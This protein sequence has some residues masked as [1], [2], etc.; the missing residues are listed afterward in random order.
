M[1]TF[2]LPLEVS[3]LSSFCVFFLILKTREFISRLT[4]FKNNA[5]FVLHKQMDHFHNFFFFCCFVATDPKNA[6]NCKQMYALY[7]RQKTESFSKLQWFYRT[8]FAECSVG[9]HI[10]TRCIVYWH[11]FLL[12]YCLPYNSS[13]EGIS[14]VRSVNAMFALKSTAPQYDYYDLVAQFN[15]PMHRCFL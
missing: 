14:Y 12:Y 10:H 11:V 13:I 3:T 15:S 9:M 8:Q 4:N 1:Q 2:L 6:S 7:E 5:S